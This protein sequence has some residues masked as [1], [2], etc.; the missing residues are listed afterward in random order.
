M[1]DKSVKAGALDDPIWDDPPEAAPRKEQRSGRRWW[2]ILIVGALSA[3]LAVGLTLW[4]SGS[5]H[6]GGDPGGRIVNELKSATAAMPIGSTHVVTHNDDSVWS[7][8][9]PDNP[10]GQ[11]GWSAVRVDTTFTTALSHAQVLAAVNSVLDHDGWTRHEESFGPGQGA[12][13]LWTKRLATATLGE[14]AVYPASHR[15]R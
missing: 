4:L 6:S 8:K 2:S 13:A 11:A 5:G 10:S 14:V 15:D 3:L 9:C 1:P 12:T 7:P